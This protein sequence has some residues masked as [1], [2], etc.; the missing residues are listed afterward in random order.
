MRKYLIAL[1]SI[2]FFVLLPNSVLAAESSVFT[3]EATNVATSYRKQNVNVQDEGVL[4]FSAKTYNGKYGNQLTGNAKK[5][6]KELVNYYYTKQKTGTLKLTS[7]AS[8][9]FKVKFKGG[10]PDESTTDYRKAAEKLSNDFLY[11]SEAF[12]EDYPEVF[13]LNYLDFSCG[14]TVYKDKSY[15]TGYRGVL[16]VKTIYPSKDKEFPGEYFKGASKKIK[17]YN[18]GVKKAVASIKKQINHKNSRLSIYLG[19][20][21]YVCSKASYHIK[22]EN[23]S[24]KDSLKYMY[25]STSANLFLSKP[26]K[27]ER[28][29][30]CDGY[31]KSF[32]VLCDA[33]G[34]DDSCATIVGNT[35]EGLHEWNYVK[36]NSKWYLIDTTWDD[37]GKQIYDT[38]LLA[39]QNSIG[40]DG[41]SIKKERKAYPYFSYPTCK[42]TLPK[43]A[44]NYYNVNEKI[45]PVLKFK[46]TSV[47]KKYSKKL[48][49]TNKLTRKET[50]GK[51]TYRS[52]NKKIATVNEKTGKV[53]VVGKGKVTITATAKAGKSYKKG[54]KKY[55]LVIK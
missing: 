49:F 9:T 10:E 8:V 51:I 41:V 19:I 36:I 15:S 54:S 29:L 14:I 31:A 3:K 24:E 37:Q 12:Q 42:F 18:N 11:A 44:S 50:D 4:L 6:Y 7:N 35:A 1:I 27:N 20:H 38:Y 34:L 21:D 22:A 48:T 39:G 47:T 16:K 2:L 28:K 25:A 17:D 43:L 5:M 32:K 52:S 53:T 46:S 33:F 45:T 55:T 40:Y 23:A 26:Y 30:L 13:W